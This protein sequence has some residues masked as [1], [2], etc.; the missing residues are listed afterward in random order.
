MSNHPFQYPFSAYVAGI[1]SYPQLHDALKNFLLDYPRH[2]KGCQQQAL[3]LLA[4]QL[5]NQQQLHALETII[6]SP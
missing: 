3:S 2:A 4:N 5:I 1:L 6:T